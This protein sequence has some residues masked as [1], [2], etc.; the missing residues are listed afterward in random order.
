MVNSASISAVLEAGFGKNKTITHL[1]YNIKL[2]YCSIVFIINTIRQLINV[3][4]K[5]VSV[6]CQ[7]CCK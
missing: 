5:E 7:S 3:C 2:T 6:V 4:S 1:D